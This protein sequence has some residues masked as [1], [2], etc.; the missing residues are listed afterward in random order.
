MARYYHPNPR[1]TVD[2]VKKIRLTWLLKKGYIK[3]SNSKD[4]KITLSGNTEQIVK[5]IYVKCKYGG[6]KWFFVCGY[7]ECTKRV[8]ILY[9]HGDYFACRTCANLSYSSCNTSNRHRAGYFKV[10][11]KAWGSDDYYLEHVKTRFYK[12]KP[13]RKY[14]R[15]LNMR[16][17]SDKDALKAEQEMYTFDQKFKLN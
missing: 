17:I 9:E 7:R 4:I 3:E 11:T 15:Y 5:M 10:L 6:K 2:Q 14:K 8:R 12:G 1:N 16:H 13:T